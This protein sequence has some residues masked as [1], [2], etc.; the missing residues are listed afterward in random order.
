[1]SFRRL[2]LAV[3]NLVGIRMGGAMIGLFSQIL[4]ARLDRKSTRLN[5]SH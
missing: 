5:S 3:I 1:M 4:L 2:A